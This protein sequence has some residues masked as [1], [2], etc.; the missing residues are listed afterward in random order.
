MNQLPCTI[1]SIG[2]LIILCSQEQNASEGTT[3]SDES[4]ANDGDKSEAADDSEGWT[5]ILGWW[6][7]LVMSMNSKIARN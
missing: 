3:E 4:E 1:F 7:K 5:V 6:Q 2:N